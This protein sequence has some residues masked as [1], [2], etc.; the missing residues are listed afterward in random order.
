MNFEK[1]WIPTSA[2]VLTDISKVFYFGKEIG[3]VFP[4]SLEVLLIYPNFF[5][6]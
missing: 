6:S 5:R 2:P 1:T 4:F 3:D